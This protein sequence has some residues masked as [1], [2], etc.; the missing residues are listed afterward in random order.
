MRQ[1]AAVAQCL[2]VTLID[3]GLTSAA[4]AHRSEA[5]AVK[6]VQAFGENLKAS[7][8]DLRQSILQDADRGRGLELDEPLDHTLTLATRLGVPTPI[9]ALCC[10]VLRMV[11]RSAR[12]PDDLAQP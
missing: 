2:N 10:R 11:S 5:E 1:T 6:I 9:L 8:P 4:L 7:A 3:A 12:G